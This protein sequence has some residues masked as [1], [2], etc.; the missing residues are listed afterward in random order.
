MVLPEF[1]PK[2]ILRS[3]KVTQRRRKDLQSYIRSLIYILYS[4]GPCTD[5][6]SYVLDIRRVLFEFLD[7]PH[8][9][10]VSNFVLEAGDPIPDIGGVGSTPSTSVASYVQP[11][12]PGM[13]DT[14]GSTTLHGPS[15]LDEEDKR[16]KEEANENVRFFL[17][18]SVQD[19]EK[20][21]STLQE[22]RD[23]FFHAYKHLD[24]K[25]NALKARA[26]EVTTI[27]NKLF[28]CDV[29]KIAAD[30]REQAVAAIKHS[31]G[32]AALATSPLASSLGSVASPKQPPRPL[33]MEECLRVSNDNL[34][35][36]E[37]EL[38][39]LRSRDIGDGDVGRLLCDLALRLL[40]QVKNVNEYQGELIRR[41]AQK[42]SAFDEEFSGS[43]GY[44][45]S[46]H[47]RP[48]AH[49]KP[50]TPTKKTKK[51]KRG[52]GLSDV[53][54]IDSG[55]DCSGWGYGTEEGLEDVMPR[56]SL[57]EHCKKL[58]EDLNS[59]R[60]DIEDLQTRRK[61]DGQ[62]K[63]H[64]VQRIRELEQEVQ[65]ARAIVRRMIRERVVV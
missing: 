21:C 45:S 61:A 57:V 18:K 25:R 44:R 54:E 27:I 59:A 7:N 52:K 15:I 65:D 19:L 3:L 43:G 23:S 17:F 1:P 42:E 5:L 60:S 14:S 13:S 64:L 33:T 53:S 29:S 48:S 62:V 16:A 39:V 56:E 12:S 31:D 2:K 20:R 22:E 32:S 63:T 40:T 26:D 50:P 6:R 8:R 47:E 55:T 36:L 34:R 9:I 4:F 58:K 46:V 37:R 10:L 30:S 38:K 51:G 35:S 49:M 28:D 41:A 24:Q 11:T